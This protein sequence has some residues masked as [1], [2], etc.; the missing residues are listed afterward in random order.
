MET[1]TEMCLH[2]KNESLE[3]LEE[4]S[5]RGKSPDTQ[6]H[7]SELPRTRRKY[8]NMYSLEDQS[9][10]LDCLSKSLKGLSISLQGEINV[11]VAVNVSK[12]MN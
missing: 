1:N 5:N 9:S 10:T 3:G 8:E 12:D 7:Y 6:Q 2:I 11:T 4:T